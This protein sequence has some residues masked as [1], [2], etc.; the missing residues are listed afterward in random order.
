[1]SAAMD[2][3]ESLDLDFIDRELLKERL[4]LAERRERWM[5]HKDLLAPIVNAM[6]KLGADVSFPN[7]LDIGLVGDRHVLAKAVRI[8]RTS[9]YSFP[10]AS[11]PKKGDTTWSQFFRCE[12]CA[13]VVF[14]RF[15]SSVCRRVQTGTQMVE[16]PIFETVCDSI[17]LPLVEDA[18]TNVV[19][20]NPA[21]A[22]DDEVPF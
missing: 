6:R 3:I 9:G 15:S 21:P 22:I 13:V 8:L 4:D 11:R 7:S 17:E 19:A 10:A 18:S 12:G 5:L 2:S 16:Q 20:F 1:M 14:F